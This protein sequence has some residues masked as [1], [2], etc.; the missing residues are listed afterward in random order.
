[1]IHHNKTSLTITLAGDIIAICQGDHCKAAILAVLEKLTMEAT[2]H[3]P[4][5]FVTQH[6][7]SLIMLKLYSSR[8]IRN[9]LNQMVKE[10]LI[11][12]QKTDAWTRAYEY[13]LNIPY[14]NELLRALPEQ[15]GKREGDE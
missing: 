9:T 10:K 14:I 12:K 1:M 3:G 2:D 4:F 13:K 11:E 8:T 7:L 5:F 6:D 15:S